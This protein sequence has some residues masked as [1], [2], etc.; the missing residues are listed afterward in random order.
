MKRQAEL[1]PAECSC[2]HRAPAQS[3]EPS[4]PSLNEEDD[5]DQKDDLALNGADQRLEQLVGEARK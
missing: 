1:G 3:K 2:F 4:R 5:E